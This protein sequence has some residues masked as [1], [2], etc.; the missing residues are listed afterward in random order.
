MPINKVSGDVQ[1]E[2]ISKL[3]REGIQFRVGSGGVI[4][5]NL[6]DNDAINAIYL[7]LLNSKVDNDKNSFIFADEELVAAFNEFLSN[8][9]GLD[10]IFTINGLKVSWSEVN[11]Q[12]AKIELDKFFNTL[13]SN[14]GE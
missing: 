2:L 10:K 4:Y 11:S 6:E 9:N 5:F 8:H 1:P 14:N 7:Q 12:R 13:Y 3:E